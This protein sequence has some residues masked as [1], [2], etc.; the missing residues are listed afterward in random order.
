MAEKNRNLEKKTG[1]GLFWRDLKKSLREMGLF[2]S[3][4]SKTAPKSEAEEVKNTKTEEVIADELLQEMFENYDP[5]IHNK[6]LNKALRKKIIEAENLYRE[7]IITSKDLVAP[8]SVMITPY[9]MRLGQKWVRTL[10]VFNYPRFLEANWLSGIINYD[11]SFDLSMFVYPTSNE[12]IMKILRRKVA[13]MQSTRNMNSKGGKV[14][15]PELDI[16]LND[17]ETLRMD[18]QKGTERF[19][20]LGMYIT[21]YA[22]SEEAL[23]KN[24]KQVQTLLGGLL[25]MTRGADFRVERGF[26]STLPQATDMVSLTRN[27]NTAPLS[28]TFPF[29]SSTLTS[30]E[31]ILY[32]LNRHNN[33][34][35][36]FDRFNL[37]NANQVVFAKSG[38]GKSYAVKLDILRSLMLGTDVIVLDP[39]NEYEQ[40]AKTVGGSYIR[41][42]LSSPQRINPFDLPPKLKDQET[43]PGDLLRENIMNL[44]GLL[45]LMLG[46]LNPYE[47]SMM[48]KA[49]LQV[50]A[51]KGITMETE[52]PSQHEMPTM[53]DLH[54]V[55]M[56][57]NEAESLA[58]RLEKYT[59]GTFSGIFNEQ[60]NVDLGK[61]LVVFSIR[62]LEESLRPMAM[63][64]LLNFI[65]ARV[66]SELRRRVLVV[67]EAWNIVQYD[68][69]A[70]FLHNLAK[71]ARKYYLGITTITQDVEDFLN[72]AWGKPIITNSSIQLLLRQSPSAVPLLQKVFNLTEGEKYL[73]LNSAVG[74]GLFFAGNSHVAIQ[75]IASK[76]EDKIVTTKPQDVQENNTKK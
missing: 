65:W 58:V 37:E 43:K 59:A 12:K 2:G 48:D 24:V 76:S 67:D 75:I 14:S 36:I 56:R 46:K 30:N 11:A 21:I 66:R 71:R 4:K 69:S 47:Q 64:I 55:L 51:E 45:D 17:A 6:Q 54:R 70:R 39:E 57:V 40:L 62:D 41:V 49:L 10:T 3:K 72:S 44:M 26:D 63:Y 74:Q 34:L 32:G 60:T 27:M 23:N 28:T 16:A 13:E 53:S 22:D 5:R 8:S 50:Y 35:I 68:Q 25:V 38:A 31:G 52:D 73:L 33:S 61:G 20:Q 7:G 1:P 18:L 15:D 42:S 19:F 9:N 29:V